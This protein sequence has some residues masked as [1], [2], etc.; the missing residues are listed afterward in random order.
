MKG[1]FA[2]SDWTNR[3]RLVSSCFILFRLVS[4]CFIFEFI[5]FTLS[6]GKIMS[7]TIPYISITILHSGFPCVLNLVIRSVPRE[8]MPSTRVQP[9]VAE[10]AAAEVPTA[11]EVATA[12]NAP[13]RSPTA[14][15]RRGG[16]TYEVENTPEHK[17]ISPMAQ[18]PKTEEKLLQRPVEIPQPGDV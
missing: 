12:A 1:C 16:T 8:S 14:T 5:V 15:R 7:T 11:G 3:F 9:L 6:I 4:S 13:T 2:S 10:L 17:E 18:P